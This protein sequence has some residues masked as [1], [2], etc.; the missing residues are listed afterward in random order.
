VIGANGAEASILGAYIIHLP[1]KNIFCFA[2][3]YGFYSCVNASF[4]IFIL[5]VY[6]AVI[7]WNW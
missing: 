6:S 2:F 4:L 7:L 5:V 3:N 1:K